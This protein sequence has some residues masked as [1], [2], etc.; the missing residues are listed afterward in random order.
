MTELEC[1]S[2]DG[3]SR[4]DDSAIP[5]NLTFLTPDSTITSPLFYITDWLPYRVRLDEFFGDPIVYENAL[6]G[7][8]LGVVG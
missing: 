5:L 8:F 2:G 4:S 3:D 1:P 7:T 6:A